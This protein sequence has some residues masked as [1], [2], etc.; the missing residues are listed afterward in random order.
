MTG[1]TEATR[2]A[3]APGPLAPLAGKVAL[4]TGSARGQGE[5]T[6]R[7]FVAAGAQVM[8]TDI[9]A[10]EGAKVAA[11]LG[12]AAVFQELDV[13]DETAWAAAVAALRASFGRLDVLVNN[14]AIHWI[15]PLLEDNAADLDRLLAVNLRGPFLGIQACVPLMLEGDG[16]SIINISSI[17]GVKAFRGHGVYG[18]AKWALRGMSKVAALELAP[19]IRV[20]CILPGAIDSPMLPPGAAERVS[21]GTPMGRLGR[22]DEIA[23]GALYLASAASS[24]TTGTDLVIDGGSTTGP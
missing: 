20:N 14:A 1:G 19:R 16:G 12:D 11:S 3:G 23:E 17:A 7:R 5:V 10:G 8:I 22:S 15:R 2:A 6:A 13:R 18:A 4:I 24:Y 9:L 21:A